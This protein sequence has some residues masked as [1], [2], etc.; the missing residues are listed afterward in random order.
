M[1]IEVLE[2]RLSSSGYHLVQ[3]DSLEIPDEIALRWLKAGWAR[4]V[5]GQVPTGTRRVLNATLE[6]E[7]AVIGQ[8]AAD[9][10][11]EK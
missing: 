7:D 3:G 10:T 8:S 6:V 9:P 1:K 4:D 11:L 5:S 2:A